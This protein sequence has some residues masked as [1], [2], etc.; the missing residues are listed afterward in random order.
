MTLVQIISYA[1]GTTCTS[2]NLAVNAMTA[3]SV[4]PGVVMAL[5]EPGKQVTWSNVIVPNVSGRY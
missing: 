5:T 4:L 2:S 3:D 1:G